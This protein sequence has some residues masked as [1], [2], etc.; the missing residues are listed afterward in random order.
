MDSPRSGIVSL[1]MCSKE[2]VQAKNLKEN[3]GNHRNAYELMES[4]P[5]DK[6]RGGV[7]NQ[8]VTQ[9]ACVF[10]FYVFPAFPS[11]VVLPHPPRILRKSFQAKLRERD[12]DGHISEIREG[13]Y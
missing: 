8:V 10:K 5:S 12:D 2:G 9:P 11:F 6:K 4:N 7:F 1:M 3:N 13:W